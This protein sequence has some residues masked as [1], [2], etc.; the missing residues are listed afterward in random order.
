MSQRKKK[1]QQL[2][3]KQREQFQKTRPLR[4]APLPDNVRI[5]STPAGAAKMSEVLLDF[6]EPY[7]DQWRT[8]EELKKLL[9][10]AIVAWNAALISGDE[11]DEMLKQMALKVPPDFRLEL[12][13]ILEPMI[14]RKLL[15]FASNTRFILSCD[16]TMT[17]NGPHVSVMSTL[18]EDGTQ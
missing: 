2:R 3:K 14:Q 12:I 1:K 11:R 13:S 7:S 18:P 8:L 9:S 4:P 15:Y 17:A 5:I 10:L 16:V 6:I